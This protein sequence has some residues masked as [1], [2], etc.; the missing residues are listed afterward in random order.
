MLPH[1]SHCTQP[2]DIGCFSVLKRAYGDLV[3]TM[4]AVGVYYIDKPTF[5]ELLFEA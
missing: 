3:K 2:L 1:L 4:I 5:L